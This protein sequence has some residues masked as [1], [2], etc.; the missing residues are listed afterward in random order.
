MGEESCRFSF[1]VNGCA[2]QATHPRT[3]IDTIVHPLITQWRSMAAGSEQRIVVFLAAPPAAGKSTL[4]LL[5]E[6]LSAMDGKAKIQALGMDGFHHYQRYIC[7][8]SVW[9]EGEERPMKAVK[10]CPESFDFDRLLAYVKRL[11]QEDVLTWPLYDRSIHDVVDDVIEVSAPIV[12]LEGNYLLLDETPWKQLSL[13]CDDSIFIVAQEQAV[14]ARLIQRKLAGGMP[15]HEALAFCERSDLRN[16]RRIL[17]HVLPAQHVLE[18]TEG[19]YHL[20]KG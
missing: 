14:R 20:V 7:S 5:F 6:Q 3:F 11:K 19:A 2:V 16:V 1:V 18:L 15:P 4:S 10:G 13:H 12:L 9:V 17:A 8:H